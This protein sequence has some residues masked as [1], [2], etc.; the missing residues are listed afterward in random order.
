MVFV[1]G[2]PIAALHE[3]YQAIVAQQQQL[4][5]HFHRLEIFKHNLLRSHNL[6]LPSPPAPDA[7]NAMAGTGRPAA[8]DN[9][10]SMLPQLYQMVQGGLGGALGNPPG[11]PPL[12]PALPPGIP[13]GV[14]GATPNLGGAAGVPPNP[15]LPP[16]LASGPGPFDWLQMVAAQAQ[17]WLSANAAGGGPGPQLPT[18]QLLGGGGQ[19]GPSEG[20]GHSMKRGAASME[21]IQVIV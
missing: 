2:N 3:Q 18:Q 17:N 5:M 7:M 9:F 1:Q 13:P 20:R 21:S 11:P 16:G 10:G 6:P 8:I 4:L 19:P 12:G 15:F 14:P